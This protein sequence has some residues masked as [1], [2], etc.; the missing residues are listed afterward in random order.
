[1]MIIKKDGRLQEFDQNKISTSI[2]NAAKSVSEMSLNSSDI[3]VIALDVI[4]KIK[5]IRKDGTNTSSYEV[6]GVI[7]DILEKDGF[8]NILR[9]FLRFD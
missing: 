5:D 9:E 2:G 6:I 3:N 1:M 7:A 8:A 4:K